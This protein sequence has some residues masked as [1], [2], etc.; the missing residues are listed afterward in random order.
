MSAA[1]TLTRAALYARRRGLRPPAFLR[2]PLTRWLQKLPKPIKAVEDWS[3]RLDGLPLKDPPPKGRPDDDDLP[4]I[5][6]P[7][8]PVYCLLVVGNLDAGGTEEV[9]AFLA[10]RLP[11]A[12]IVTALAFTPTSGEQQRLA[13]RLRAE[14]IDVIEANEA[15]ASAVIRSFGAQVV[16]AHGA[17]RWWVEAAARARVPYVETLHG[18]LS[19]FGTDWT[20]EA[21]RSQ[22]ISAIVA[23]SELVRRQYLEGNAT[24]DFERMFTVPNS[25]E[26]KR[27]PH[28]DREEARAWLGLGS[29]FLFVSLARHSLPKN[30]YGL[31]MAFGDVATRRSDAHLLIAGR[32]DDLHYAMQ[33]A[34]LRDGMS[35]R[36]RIHLR[37]HTP[38]PAVILAAADA[39]VMNSY[40]EGCSLASMEALCA[41]V[42]VI[43]SDVGGAREQVDGDMCRG[44]VVG[45]PLGDPL[46]ANWNTVGASLY[47]PQLNRRELAAAMI[48]MMEAGENSQERRLQLRQES[49]L[50]FHPSKAVE[51]HASVLH[52]VVGKPIEEYSP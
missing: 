33:V 11:E 13:Q 17:P 39:F 9:A 4:A 18:M 31:V 5:P 43:L 27:L 42:P 14:G 3:S 8:A 24:F 26:T 34:A 46:I 48:R 44:Y 15:S 1:S 21:L 35:C 50:R 32:P 36:N 38:W 10:R 30:Q 49:R 2:Q 7:G 19:M 25:V 28:V 40:F 37:D 20:A 41:G 22:K 51:G 16:S 29:E 23:V 6:G 47:A 12:G 45:N 52:S